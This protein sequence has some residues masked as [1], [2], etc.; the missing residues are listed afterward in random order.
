MKRPIVA[1]VLLLCMQIAGVHA[2]VA[3]QAVAH[4]PKAH[5][6]AHVKGHG[7]AHK[8]KKAQPKPHRKA[9]LKRR[10]APPKPVVTPSAPAPITPAGAK[11]RAAVTATPSIFVTPLG[12]G[13]G[14][15]WSQ[16]AAIT[17]LPKLVASAAPGAIVALAA[18]TGAYQ[19]SAPLAIAA[20]GA[21]DHPITIE[22]L[23]RD[24]SPASADIVGTRV[25]PYVASGAPGAEVFR[26]AAGSAH[27]AFNDLQFSNVGDPFRFTGPTSDV[28][29]SNIHATNV[30]RFLLTLADVGPA[31]V[32]GMTVSNVTIDGFSKDA[33]KIG[34]DSSNI[35]LSDVVGDSEGQDGDNFAD[36]VHLVD[37]THDVL[38][39][40][41]T[42]RDMT[43]TTS[44]YWNGDGFTTEAGVSDIT[45]DHTTSADNTDAGYDLKS[46][47]NTLSYA[48]ASR[49]KRNFRIWSD[50]T[51]VHCTASDPHIYGGTG[52]QT[53]LWLND[54]ATVT[55]SQSTFSDASAATLVFDLEA[56][57]NLHVGQSVITRGTGSTLSHLN[58]GAVLSLTH[59]TTT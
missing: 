36:G 23:N 37:T 53:Q 4:H 25:T 34:D 13:D 9:P 38:L 20:V 33:F 50:A 45:F 21:T 51:M 48:V 59:N 43:D 40:R 26:I 46:T 54:D 56:D 44:T 12:V 22:G 32:T 57:A 35:V 58:S 2:A 6:K 49:N 31:S 15:S 14:S 18:D 16:A 3:S 24:G 7:K 55:A 47:G 5:G 1:P 8:A 19:L 30:R 10:P 27:V 41:V 39:Q 11:A 29:I 52:H 17:S 28:S 42:M